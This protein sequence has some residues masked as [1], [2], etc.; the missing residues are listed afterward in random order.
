[1]HSEFQLQHRTNGFISINCRKIALT[2]NVRECCQQAERHHY[3]DDRDELPAAPVDALAEVTADALPPHRDHRGGV[4][5]WQWY[6]SKADIR[7]R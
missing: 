7:F 6:P 1:M 3:H 4:A 2:C 5:V